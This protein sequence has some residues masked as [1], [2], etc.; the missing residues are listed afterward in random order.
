MGVVAVTGAGA[1][2]GSAVA[3]A[4]GLAAAP[5]S[6]ELVVATVELGSAMLLAGITHPESQRD[7]TAAMADT[8]KDITRHEHRLEGRFI[9]LR[10][11][12]KVEPRPGS[13]L[14][15]QNI[16]AATTYHEIDPGLV[17]RANPASTNAVA[18]LQ[19]VQPGLAGPGHDRV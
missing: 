9:G 15:R 12:R 3:D 7:V 17:L 2:R 6:A 14:G 19:K 16:L 11:V 18:R 13:L 1:M 10:R 8:D 5:T 4:Q